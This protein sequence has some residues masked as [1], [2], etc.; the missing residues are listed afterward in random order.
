MDAPLVI[1][2]TARTAVKAVDL[3]D[4][5]T[6]VEGYLVVFDDPANPVKDLAGD[7]FTS[8]TY[9]G[10][11]GGDGVDCL[12]HHGIPVKKGLEALADV[13]LPPLSVKADEHGLFASVVLDM[14]DEYQAAIAD[15]AAKKKLGWSSGSAPHMVKRADDGH[16]TRWPII[17]GSLTPQ[18][19]EPRTV[20]KSIADL[21]QVK[22]VDFASGVNAARDRVQNAAR[23]ALP[24][25]EWV[26]VED[27]YPDAAIVSMDDGAEA[28]RI[29]VTDDGET[30]TLAPRSEW[31]EVERVTDWAAVQKALKSAR[32]DLQADP[33]SVLL[34]ALRSTREGFSRASGA[35]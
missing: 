8:S 32:R 13:V 11:R 16:L 7:Y 26:W 4:G 21:P 31:T 14:A 5:T 6:R 34:S 1:P 23:L 9:F 10:A 22:A 30:V 3:G 25:A 24:G 35:V 20:M 18:P 2:R 12:F 28:Y 27:L 19:C 15:L 33:E 29:P 17:E